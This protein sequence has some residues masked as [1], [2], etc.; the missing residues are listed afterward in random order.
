MLAVTIVSHVKRTDIQ[1]HQQIL[2]TWTASEQ[3]Y[4][5]ASLQQH[6]TNQVC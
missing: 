2:S 5:R 4:W 6:N 3:T 1:Q